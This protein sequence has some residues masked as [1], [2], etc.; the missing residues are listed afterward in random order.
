MTELEQPRIFVAPLPIRDDVWRY[1]ITVQPIGKEAM[2]RQ[3]S[4]HGAKLIVMAGQPEL[5]VLATTLEL[6]AKELLVIAKIAR[7]NPPE[8]WKAKE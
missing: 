4:V 6:A 7:R 2:K 3:I 5:S 1:E 8:N